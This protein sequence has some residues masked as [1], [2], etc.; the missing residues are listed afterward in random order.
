[1]RY[2]VCMYILQKCI[3]HIHTIDELTESNV[4]CYDFSI[5]LEINWAPKAG[6]G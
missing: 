2:F 3:F 6:C 1:M 4:G 5:D